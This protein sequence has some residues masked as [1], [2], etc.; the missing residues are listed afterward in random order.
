MKNN[1]HHQDITTRIPLT[2]EEGFKIL[3][4]VMPLDDKAFAIQGT[5][6]EFV[7]SEHFELGMWIRNHW[8]YPPEDANNDT[9]ERYMKCCAMLT[10]TKPDEPMLEHPDSVS[11]EFLGRYYDHLKESVHVNDPAIPVRRK[12]VKCPHCGSK[13]LRIQYGYPGHEM[14][15]AAERGEI[16]LGG[17]CISP[18]SP[19]YGCP[20]CGQPFIKTV[21]YD[22]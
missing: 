17:C 8:L 15:E 9:V 6:E 10:G 2:E 13:V 7:T 12:P 11:G 5:K 4:E 3:D 18:D 21:F 22:R 19:D 20:T 16:L 14:M 1:E